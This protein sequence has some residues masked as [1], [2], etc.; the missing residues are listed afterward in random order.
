[1]KKEM[2]K[3]EVPYIS[4]EDCNTKGLVGAE[5]GENVQKG[6][7]WGVYAYKRGVHFIEEDNETEN[8]RGGS[9]GVGKIACNAASDIYM[10]FFAN[11]DETGK[12]HIGGTIELRDVL[13][14]KRMKFIIRMRIIL[15]QSLKRRQE[16]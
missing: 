6:D 12:Q 16:G 4:F 11:C 1:M 9:H 15:V 13:Q 14:E 8:M 3:H 10:M 2:S 7:T 5:H